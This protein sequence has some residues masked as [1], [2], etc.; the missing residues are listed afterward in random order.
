MINDF[1]V[2]AYS[3]AILTYY[4]GALIYLLPI[5]L[6]S[7]K[8]WAPTLIYDSFAVTIL[9]LLFTSIIEFISHFGNIFGVSWDAY[10]NWLINR[11]LTLGSFISFLIGVSLA[12]SYAGGKALVSS[13]LGPITSIA[14]YTLIIMEFFLILGLVFKE[15]FAK[16]LALG[17]LLYA[18]PFRIAR[19]AGASLI[20]LS[21][22]FTIALPFLPSFVATM[23]I[24]EEN[25]LENVNF[26]NTY[27]ISNLRNELGVFFAKGRIV[28]SRDTPIP[29]VESDWYINYNGPWRI[30]T[31]YTNIEGYY[32]AGR[33]TGGLPLNVDELHVVFRYFGT[34]LGETN[35]SP[36]DFKYNP[37]LDPNS[38]YI[39]DFTLNNTVYLGNTVLLIVGK[40]CK[41]DDVRIDQYEAI[42]SFESLSEGYVKVLYVPEVVSIDVVKVS[43]GDTNLTSN[44]YLWN[45]VKV[46]TVEFKISK[47]RSM[48]KVKFSSMNSKNSFKVMLK[49][50]GYF[51]DITTTL[52]QG[53]DVESL[54]K[55]IG[56]V[57]F[58]WIILPITYLTILISITYSFAYVLGGRK[59]RIPIR[60]YV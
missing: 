22:V 36:K 57:F 46:S 43:N 32:D 3:L 21:I 10:F 30:A 4:L 59:L 33:P 50:E 23:S 12:V 27:A 31:Y 54:G 38:D 15:Y 24:G 58:Q 56:K 47:G 35:V 51:S 14:T 53:F 25:P 18:I 2:L 9:V 55:A 13:F 52:S 34:E 19:S 45:N 41:I 48:V 37:Y 49:D 40:V 17:I 28:D 8:K 26:K 20:A 60:D 44:E 29:Y 11:T 5:P 1:L 7:I 39:Y 16:I 42:I 6:W